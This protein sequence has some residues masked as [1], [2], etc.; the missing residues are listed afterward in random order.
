MIPSTTNFAMGKGYA[1]SDLQKLQKINIK[2]KEK[3]WKEY[4]TGDKNQDI[5]NFRNSV[6]RT[7]QIRID[8]P[9][10]PK[11][12]SKSRITKGLGRETISNDRWANFFMHNYDTKHKNDPEI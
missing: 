5:D 12:S 7:K 3:Q 2:L 10:I 8:E 9:K 4:K 1:K 6:L 11:T